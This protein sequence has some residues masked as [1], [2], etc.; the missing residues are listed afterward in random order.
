MSDRNIKIKWEIGR[1]FQL[2]DDF[3]KLLDSMDTSIR[4]GE[5]NVYD[6]ISMCAWS[7]GRF[8]TKEKM[9][10]ENME[11]FYNRGINI[12]IPLTN[13]NV[14]LTDRLGNETLERF[15]RKGNRIIL[16]DEDLIKYINKN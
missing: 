10:Y 9:K 13:R 14:D 4:Y 11:E 5:L 15:Y 8:V 6:G 12:S 2:K 7:G 3:F 16:C 1:A